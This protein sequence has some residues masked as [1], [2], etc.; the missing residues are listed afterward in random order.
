[1][2]NI[3]F[4]GDELP[5]WPVLAVGVFAGEDQTGSACADD[6]RLQAILSAAI[7]ADRACGRFEGKPGECISAPLPAGLPW[8]RLLIAGL[9]ERVGW[10]PG[11]D[12]LKCIGGAIVR[13][14][15]ARGERGV[16][17]DLRWAD[18]DLPDAAVADI[19]YGARL[20]SYRF[21]KWRTGTR[22]LEP[23]QLEELKIH[24]A[25]PAEVCDAFGR[26]SPIAAGTFLARDLVNEPPNSMTPQ[27]FVDALQ[28][29]RRLG[30]ELEVLDETDLAR[31]GMEG[32]LAVGGGSVHPPR[33]L[34]L[35]WRGGAHDEAPVCL[36]GKGITFDTGGLDLKPHAMLAPMKGDMAG[37]AAVAGALL[38]LARSNE[39]VNA[40]G[41]IPLAEN[42]LSGASF[43]P[44]DIIRLARGDTIEIVNTDAEGR[45][46]LA[47]AIW[48]ARTRFSPSTIISLG[49]LGG[50]GFF[51]LGLRYGGLYCDDL[52]LRERMIEAGNR[53]SEPLWHL[54]A[55]PELD[56]DL[57]QS[58]VADLLQATDYMVH[59]NDSGYIVRL[60]KRSAG[61]VPWAH[62]EMTRLEFAIKDRATC[63]KGATGFGAALLYAATSG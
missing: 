3:D 30:I 42:A 4:C 2:M 40:V 22:T 48:Y 14:A 58:D 16:H 27:G 8:R 57:R 54:P 15:A 50:S 10:T 41:V 60:L 49:T 21:R 29:F 1:M 39:P 18:C 44:S 31:E 55:D 12:A 26:L 9:G 56:E 61:V 51:G 7:A 24:V 11:R 63:P 25:R 45:V 38:A 47:D 28:D 59:G 5:R 36:V 35:R 13:E 33:L 20:G 32:I 19:A 17:L 23:A 52:P 6:A 43:R 62:V 34:I 46:V 53:A 37:G